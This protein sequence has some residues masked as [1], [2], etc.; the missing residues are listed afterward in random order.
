MNE[1]LTLSYVA[2]TLQVSI[3][4]EV[5]HH[6]AKPLR[7]AIDRAIF[8]YRPKVLELDFSAVRFMDSSGIALILGRLALGEDFGFALVLCGLAPTA[9][10]LLRLCG[11]EGRQN[12]TVRHAR[13]PITDEG[14]KR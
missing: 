6:K 2:D 11:I 1:N 4:C 3:L 12:I 14:D 13:A 7:E 5:D 10:K 9:E 8:A